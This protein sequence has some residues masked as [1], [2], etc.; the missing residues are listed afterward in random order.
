LN[1]CYEAPGLVSNICEHS[2]NIADSTD[3]S[4]FLIYNKL[5]II[6]NDST[7]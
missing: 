6:L 5:K 2:P 3:S 1:S 4:N 7:D